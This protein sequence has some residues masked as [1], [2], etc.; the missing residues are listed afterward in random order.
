LARA[1]PT[2]DHFAEQEPGE[3]HGVARY[4]VPVQGFRG[5]ALAAVFGEDGGD[6]EL[7]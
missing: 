3:L 4:R 6:L 7:S 2:Y 5:E 1:E